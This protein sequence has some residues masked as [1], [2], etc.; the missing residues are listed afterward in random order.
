[1]SPGP[2]K[3]LAAILEKNRDFILGVMRSNLGSDVSPQYQDFL[4]NTQDGK[5]RLSIFFDMALESLKSTPKRFF[6]DQKKVGYYRAVQGYSLGEVTTVPLSLIEAFSI[7]LQKQYESSET[8]P[9]ELA[10]ELVE[11]NKI[12]MNSMRLVAQAYITTREERIA[13]EINNIKLLY[14]FTQNIMSIFDINDITKFLL[15]ELRKI[16]KIDNIL[17]ELPGY[18][19]MN[20]TYHNH[21]LK[22]CG[23]YRALLKKAWTKNTNYFIAEDG[24]IHDNPDFTTLKRAVIAPIRGHE[25]CHGAVMLAS[26]E[27][28]FSFTGKD[29]SLLEQLLLITTI[30]IDNSLLFD[31]LQANNKKMSLLTKQVLKIS[32]EERRRIAEDIHDSL[33]QTLTGI[34]YK[35]QYCL[36]A[37]KKHPDQIQNE[38]AELIPIVQQS[39]HQSRE[40]ISSLH[41]DII[42]NIGLVTALER[43][44]NNIISHNQIELDLNL[45]P[46]LELN[47]HMTISIYRV[48]QEALANVIKHA[49]AKN[50]KVTLKTMNGCI[51]L[52]IYD[53]GKGFDLAESQDRLPFDSKF[54]LFYIQQRVESMGGELAIKTAPNQGCSI[55]A[56]IPQKPSARGQ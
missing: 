27:K 19:L 51:F 1:M 55:E 28:G 41:L 30:V 54:G 3:A 4:L 39:I 29:M 47:S 25:R 26:K 21:D 16:F 35:L 46:N 36:E 14:L 44:T 18:D 2:A 20:K 5:R 56:T 52:Q 15:E 50:V 22:N 24:E 12:V 43:L 7:V 37:S 48:V 9:R 6:Q 40:L 17:I 32:E 38:L 53:D 10:R 49:E 31:K 23:N 42:D 11:A 34:N 33:T 8:M 13:A 45:S